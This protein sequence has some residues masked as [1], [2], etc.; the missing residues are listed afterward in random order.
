M[1]SG[2]NIPPIAQTLHLPDRYMSDVTFSNFDDEGK[3]K[4][5]I[6]VH[7]AKHYAQGNLMQYINPTLVFYSD[8]GGDWKL[9]AKKGL[10]RSGFKFLEL[11][12]N[13]I[14]HRDSSENNPEITAKTSKLSAETKLGIVST[15]EAVT[16]TQPGITINGMGLEGTLKTGNLHTLSN[17]KTNIRY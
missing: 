15:K 16:I 5:K 14:L 4:Q 3:L 11:N 2:S 12:N 9:T 8:S 1:P 13:V 17:T 7:E 6:K 10:S